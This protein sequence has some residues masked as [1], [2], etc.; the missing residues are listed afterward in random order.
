M[1]GTD[2]VGSTV[3]MSLIV[4]PAGQANIAAV[5]NTKPFAC[6]GYEPNLPGSFWDYYPFARHN[7]QHFHSG[8]C[9]WTI[10]AGVLFSR[11]CQR[12][13]KGGT[14]RDGCQHFFDGDKTYKK[15]IATVNAT[16]ENDSYF[17]P[18]QLDHAQLARKAKKFKQERDDNRFENPNAARKTQSLAQAT[19]QHKKL[20][21][22]LGQ[23]DVPRVRQIVS[24]CLKHGR[25]TSHNIDQVQRAI[26]DT[27]SANQFTYS[28]KL[29]L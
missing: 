12:V 21:M 24:V 28:N 1:N 27:Y 5:A 19:N 10:G 2:T 9:H 8:A 25:S 17:N 6:A 18:V 7:S 22:L 3:D 4:G 29:T 23:N 26:N 15:L 16:E 13:D 11:S 20:V 14:T